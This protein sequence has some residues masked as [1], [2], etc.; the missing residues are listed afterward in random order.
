VRGEALSSTTREEAVVEAELKEK[1]KT[2][3]ML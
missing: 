1:Q 2:Q 3:N